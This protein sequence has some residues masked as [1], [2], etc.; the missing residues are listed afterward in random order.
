[1]WGFPY[2]TWATIVGIVALLVGMVIDPDGRPQVLL[3][4][5]F[6]AGMFVGSSQMR[7]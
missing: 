4:L 2:L 6:A 3:S 1:M 5:V 7:V